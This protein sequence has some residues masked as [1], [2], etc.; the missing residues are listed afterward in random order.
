MMAGFPVNVLA[1]TL[2]ADGIN[3]RWQVER[4]DK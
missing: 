4:E 2:F 3:Y 1:S